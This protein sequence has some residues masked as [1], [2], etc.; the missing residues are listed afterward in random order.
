MRIRTKLRIKAM[1][2]FILSVFFL[3]IPGCKRNTAVIGNGALGWSSDKIENYV[4]EYSP[5]RIS[6]RDPIIVRFSKLPE[7]TPSGTDLAVSGDIASLSPSAPGKFIWKDA[8]T[9]AFIP[10]SGFEANSQYVL[11]LS[12]DKIYKNVPKEEARVSLALATLKQQLNL[13]MDGLNYTTGPDGKQLLQVQGHISALDFAENTEV[14]NTL[15]ALQKENNGLTLTW[16]HYNPREHAFTIGGIQRYD[17]DTDLEVTLNGKNLD[18]DFKGKRII[19]VIEKG[20][21]IF[22]SAKVDNDGTKMAQLVF[23][24]PLD[25]NQDLNG[26]IEVQGLPDGINSEINGNIIN[27]YL[28]NMA[29][30]EAIILI[31]ASVKNF[32]GKSLGNEFTKA[33]SFKPQLPEVKALRKGVIIPET[34]NIWFPFQAKNLKAVDIE[35]TKIY[36]NNVLQ[37]LQYNAID[38]HYDLMPVGKSIY[39]GKVDLTEI[40]ALSN[41]ENWQKYTLDLSK[42]INVDKGAIYNVQITFI[43]EYIDSYPCPGENVNEQGGA[44]GESDYYHPD[45]DGINPCKDYYYYYDEHYVKTNVF[46]SNLGLIA[47]G[48]TK[49][50]WNIVCTDILTAKGIAGTEIVLYDFQKQEVAKGNTDANG[51]VKLSCKDAPSFVMAKKGSTYGY[52]NLQDNYANPVNEYDVSGKALETGLDAFIYPERGVYRPGDTMHVSVMLYNHDETSPLAQNYPLRLMLEDSRGKVQYDKVLAENLRHIYYFKVPTRE[53]APTGTWKLMAVAGSEK[54]YKNVKVETVKPNRLKIRYEGLT[55]KLS[56][57]NSPQLEFNSSW[58]H[59]ASA[60]GLRA[61]IDITWSGKEAAFPKYKSYQ[62]S[63]PART[64]DP[65]PIRVFE[66]N[67]DASGKA[68]YT[69][70]DEP[71]LQPPSA[72]KAGIKTRVYEKSGNFSEDYANVDVHKYSAYTGVKIPQSEWGGNYLKSGIPQSISLVSV[73][74]KGKPLSSRKLVVGLYEAEWNWWYNESNYNILK[75]NSGQHIGALKTYNLTTNAKGEAT[76]TEK[77]EDYGNYMV[78]ICDEESG[79]CTGDFFYTSKW[80]NPPSNSDAPQLISLTSDKEDY[81]VG[82]HI[83]LRIPSNANSSIIISI[84]KGNEVI[85]L[86]HETGKDRETVMDI[87]VTL[88]MSPNIF[89]HATL[90]QPYGS[91][92]QGLPLRM[93]GILPIKI[94]DP[95]RTISPTIATQ[96]VIIPDEDFKVTVAEKQGKEMSYTL[97]VVD[98]GLLDL[99]RFKTPDPVGHFFARLA[100]GVNTWDLY[101]KV[102]NPN[103]EEIENLFSVGGD[104]ESINLNSVKKANR[105]APTV[106]FIGPFLLKP[107]QSNTHILKISK[108]VGSVRI[109][110]V[111]RSGNSFGHNELTRPVKKDLMVQNTLPR[112]LTPGDE[113]DFAANVFSMSG[114]PMNVTVNLLTDPHFKVAGNPKNTLDFRKDGDLLSYFKVS[115]GSLSGIG[116]IGSKVSAGNTVSQDETEIEIRN[117]NPERTEVKEYKIEAGKTVQLPLGL[118]GIKGSHTAELEVSNMPQFNIASRLDHLIQY[119]YGCIEQTTSAAFP[120]L[121]LADIIQLSPQ[122]Q[123]QTN[124]NIT[125]AIQ[126]MTLFQTTSGGFAYWPGNQG[127]EDWATSYAGHFLIEAKNKSFHVSDALLSKWYAYQKSRS[128][129]YNDADPAHLHAQAYRLYSMAK[130]GKPDLGAMNRMRNMKGMDK[131]SMHTLA[132]AYALSGKKDIANTLLKTGVTLPALSENRSYFDYTYGSVLRDKAMMAEAYI[133]TS[134]VRQALDLVNSISQDLNTNQWY[135]TQALSHSL[136]VV[137]KFYQTADKKGLLGSVNY[138]GKLLEKINTNKRATILSIPLNESS[139]SQGLQLTNGTQGPVYVKIMVR[140]QDGIEKILPPRS[141]NLSIKVVYTDIKGKTIDVN[142]LAQGTTFKARITVTNPGTYGSHLSQL[143]LN[144]IV[145][146]GWEITNDRLNGNPNANSNLDYQDFRDDRVVS[147]FSLT[148][149]VTIDIS[150]TATYGGSF[151]QPPVSCEA[152]YTNLVNASTG[153]GN[154][155]VRR[156]STMEK[157]LVQ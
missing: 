100:L 3:F 47:K 62:F 94:T 79:H 119:P 68:T 51:I 125:R 131:I 88:D 57:F 72:L 114:K 157:E 152:M 80:G 151:Y 122:R 76:W 19:P 48:S 156:A 104:A 20:K 115:V 127:A 35:I 139:K 46:A 145:P 2:V 44:Y 92:N 5:L 39:K 113:V 4:A 83:K 132:A 41:K 45:D 134:N 33:I 34:E 93:Y 129:A 52:L 153:L 17:E 67:L 11:E 77:F 136:L 60:D 117:P 9:L 116:K 70:K 123:Q 30:E 65:M 85:K 120:Q 6:T 55:E 23:S 105:F 91:G 31:H 15:S 7:L 27:L 137:Q 118:F 101:N 128:A 18:D 56:L 89:I 32:E 148:K 86:L 81:K 22:V 111:A 13:T 28:E 58:L 84:E 138:N 154:V 40:S 130:Y 14:E 8:L 110:V 98:E 12:L 69:L 66:G 73:D 25:K 64:I 124:Q 150:L 107:S 10:E 97:A 71:N 61:E 143:A 149:S 63:D 26:L 142:D 29:A 21:F 146:A 147:F 1:P 126:R 95:G 49:G 38:Q 78:R 43:K 109:M 50:S 87:P 135:N 155:V 24:D 103:G 106:R 141:K 144:Y 37:F 108:Y 42:M 16:D 96:S 54:F 82:D 112:V 74:T 133:S 36:Q 59:G 53:A 102:M 75:F 121:Y 90:L 99:T 140:G